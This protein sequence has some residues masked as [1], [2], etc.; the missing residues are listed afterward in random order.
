MHA[1][2]P[3]QGVV[4]V[5]VVDRELATRTSAPSKAASNCGESCE[6]SGRAYGGTAQRTPP[7]PAPHRRPPWQSYRLPLTTEWTVCTRSNL[8]RAWRA[9]AACGGLGG[10]V[11]TGRCARSAPGVCGHHARGAVSSKPA[12]AVSSACPQ[13]APSADAWL[14]RLQPRAR[15]RSARAYPCF[16]ERALIRMQY[17]VTAHALTRARRRSARA[18]SGSARRARR[19][20]GRAASP[21]RDDRKGEAKG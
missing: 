21:A 13:H 10:A 3:T 4:V 19:R 9:R 8:W 14:R 5:L 17:Q 7:Q 1:C 6:G 16:S 18:R 20:P 15:R 11:C 2:A 12:L